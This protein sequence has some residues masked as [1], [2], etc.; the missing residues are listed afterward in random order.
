MH[1]CRRGTSPGPSSVIPSHDGLAA[2]SV[3]WDIATI[4]CE[5]LYVEQGL[6]P[7]G[8]RCLN[9]L[10]TPHREPPSRG[11]STPRPTHRRPDPPHANGTDGTDLTSL[12]VHVHV[13]SLARS[14]KH[15][16]GAPMRCNSTLST[17]SPLVARLDSQL[18]KTQRRQ[19]DPDPVDYASGFWR[20]TC[21]F[22]R[23]GANGLR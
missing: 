11:G 10:F 17:S 8:R 22:S 15:G 9:T 7:A 12:H 18:N 14:H 2:A 16:P 5:T 3:V 1:S 13:S 21:V 23:F 19:R 6:N 4:Q 20:T